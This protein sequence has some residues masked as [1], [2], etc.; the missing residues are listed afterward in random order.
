MQLKFL[1]T[2]VGYKKR[3]LFLETHCITLKNQT[4]WLETL[5]GNWNIL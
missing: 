4:E 2:V 5:E 3:S 1:P